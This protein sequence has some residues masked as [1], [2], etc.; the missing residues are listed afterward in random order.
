MKQ[1]PW[2]VPSFLLATSVLLGACGGGE[3][4]SDDPDSS[5]GAQ[6]DGDTGGLSG[7]GGL[8]GSGGDPNGSGGLIGAGGTQGDGGTGGIGSGGQPTGGGPGTGGDVGVGG[9]P[10][11]PTYTLSEGSGLYTYSVGDSSMTINPADG[12]RVT[13]FIIEG[14]ETLMQP[15]VPADPDI[16]DGS[17]FWPSPQTLFD[18]PPPPEID[19]D[20]YTVLVSEDQLTLTSPNAASLGL[21]VTKIFAP[22]YSTSGVPAISITYTMTNT[23]ASALDVA[24][25]EISRVASGMAFFPTGPEG[26]LPS[27]T[28]SGTEVGAH[29]WYTY[30]ATGLMD[31]PKIFADGTGGWLSWSTGEA[32]V[33]KSFPDIELSDFAP[34]EG[35]IEI[36]A[37]PSGDYFEV[38]QQGPLESIAAGA[39]ASWTVLWIGV[40][41]PDGASTAEGSADLLQL[42]TSSL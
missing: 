34:G 17:V 23:G 15:V 3:S 14:H 41:I 18:W 30:D 12:G 13:S 4:P 21:T 26:Q 37:N 9:S 25:W 32:V 40:A 36:Y 28:L 20:A 38:E 27:S 33:I 42:V 16:H 22:T 29:T 24:G 11:V 39:S 31:V 10:P 7:V 5:G 1:L 6:G 2:R 35:E 8:V 19:S